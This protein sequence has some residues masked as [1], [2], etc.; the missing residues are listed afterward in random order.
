[1]EGPYKPSKLDCNF[2]KDVHKF[3]NIISNCGETGVS[4]ADVVW[5][6]V[7]AFAALG[8]SGFTHTLHDK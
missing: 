3:S 1:M 5:A 4:P 6:W 7:F 2:V 8:A